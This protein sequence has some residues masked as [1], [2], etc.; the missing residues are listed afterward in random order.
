MI[1]V[2][3]WENFWPPISLILGQGHKGTEAGQ[4]WACP[5][6]KVRTAFPIAPNFGRN[7]P[8]I[9]LSTWLD[10]EGILLNIFL[11]EFSC[12][13]WNPFFP[14]QSLIV[15]YLKNKWSNWCET[16]MIWID[17][18]ARWLGY[19]RP[20][21]TYWP[22]YCFRSVS[23]AAVLPALFNF[24]GKPLKHISWNYTWLSYGWGDFFATHLGDLGSRSSRYR[25]RTDL[26]LSP[27]YSKNRFF[28]RSKIW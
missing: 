9:M 8:P 10:Y 17:W 6:D 1:N 22:T 27:Q 26:N 18:M 14:T 4:I 28:N 24:L 12:K 7:I 23:A 11:N 15:L 21:P 5:R 20:W 19:L 2:W 13:I 3:V 16:K 25:S